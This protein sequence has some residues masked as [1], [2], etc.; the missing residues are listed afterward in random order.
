MEVSIR[1]RKEKAPRAI[2]VSLL[3]GYIICTVTASGFEFMAV[4]ASLLSS[5]RMGL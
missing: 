3:A 1:K 2:L 4:I 5:E